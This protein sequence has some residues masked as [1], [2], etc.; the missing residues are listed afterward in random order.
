M[1]MGAAALI[2]G[3]AG[4]SLTLADKFNIFQLNPSGEWWWQRVIPKPAPAVRMQSARFIQPQRLSPQQELSK[5]QQGVLYA[6]QIE[7]DVKRRHP[8]LTGSK[9]QLTAAQPQ[10]SIT[11]YQPNQSYGQ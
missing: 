1:G 8:E 2:A 11:P 4:V 7:K 3:V 9:Y 10:Y 6:E 5:A